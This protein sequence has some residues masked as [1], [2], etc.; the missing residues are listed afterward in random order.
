MQRFGHDVDHQ[1]RRAAGARVALAMALLS[2]LLIFARPAQA[3]IVDCKS[4]DV[5][6]HAQDPRDAELV[7][8]GAADAV[9]FFGAIGVGTKGPIILRVVGDLP[10]AGNESVLGYYSYGKQCVYLLSFSEVEKR[11]TP[12]GLP[13]NATLYQSMAT[14]EVAHVIAA[15]N[16]AAAKPPIMAREYIAYVV[17]FATMPVANRQ[18]VFS[19]FPVKAFKS[20]ADINT[21]VYAFDPTQFGVRAYKHFLKPENGPAFIRKILAGRA[22]SSQPFY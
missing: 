12:F 10:K 22:L 1:L 16:F 5:V 21:M 2:S 13:A 17:M 15:R 8:A 3:A 4:G 19:K 11:G 9:R 18:R 20:E 6:V 7:C 14:H